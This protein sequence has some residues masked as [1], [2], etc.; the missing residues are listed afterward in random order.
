[1]HFLARGTNDHNI[2]FEWD[3]R[4]FSRLVRGK[5]DEGA[6]SFHLTWIFSGAAFYLG[7]L[8]KP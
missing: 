7:S 6:S 2:K 4:A 1:V 5:K 8:E 3:V